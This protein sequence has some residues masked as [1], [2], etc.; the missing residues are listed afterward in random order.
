VGK[1]GGVRGSW[2]PRFSKEMD[3]VGESCLGK[4]MIAHT[5]ES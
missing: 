1:F 3:Q 4:K 5:W 2:V